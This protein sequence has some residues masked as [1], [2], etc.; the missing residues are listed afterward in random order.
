MK[1]INRG[2]RSLWTQVGTFHQSNVLTNKS[3]ISRIKIFP[4]G[5]TLDHVLLWWSNAP[6]ATQ[7]TSH[8]KYLRDWVLVLQPD[9]EKIE[10][11]SYEKRRMVKAQYNHNP[12]FQTPLN[13]FY[14]HWNAWASPWPSTLLS[15]RGI[16]SSV[17]PLL[18]LLLCPSTFPWKIVPTNPTIYRVRQLLQLPK[19][20][21]I[22]AASHW[23]IAMEQRVACYGARSWNPWL[24]CP[25]VVMA[26]RFRLNF[27]LWNR[28]LFCIE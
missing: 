14:P 11:R 13:Q 1:W 22:I 19:I 4:S 16:D 20:H 24:N 6:V 28:F 10:K 5:G 23:T 2:A 7:P 8:A 3:F 25:T 27:Q 15:P 21:P 12:S 26:E 9:G 17:L 18:P